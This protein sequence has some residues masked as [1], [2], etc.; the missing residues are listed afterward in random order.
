MMSGNRRKT[1]AVLVA[2]IMALTDMASGAKQIQLPLT[3]HKMDESNVQEGLKKVPM[4]REWL[5]Q[6]F[7]HLS[8]AE[9]DEL[10]E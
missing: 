4:T 8:C 7:G 5:N 1:A 10:L 9:I 3:M 6:H 2:T